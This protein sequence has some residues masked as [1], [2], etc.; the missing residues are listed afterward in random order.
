[1][2]LRSDYQYSYDNFL[3][4]S[5]LSLVVIQ[6]LIKSII[7]F[8]DLPSRWYMRHYE[9]IATQNWL[10]FLK[11]KKKKCNCNHDI[12]ITSQFLCNY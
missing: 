9:V 2:I 8:N 12:R 5:E 11:E 7:T 10:D 1:M 6:V 3:K 4:I